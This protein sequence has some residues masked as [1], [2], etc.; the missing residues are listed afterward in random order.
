MRYALQ[1]CPY[2]AIH[3]YS[4]RVDIGGIDPAKVPTFTTFVDTTMIPERPRLFVAACT[5][6]ITNITPSEPLVTVVPLRPYL[7]VE[8]WQNG[9]LLPFAEGVAIV[10][11]VLA[12]ALG[13]PF[14][15]T[16]GGAQIPEIFG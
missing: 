2:L 15:A 10:R 5:R 3:S 4:G 7:K 1:V 13:G 11:E 14:P 8:F 6:S 16:T 12:E 9:Y